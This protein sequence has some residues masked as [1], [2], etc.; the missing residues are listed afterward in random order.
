MIIVPNLRLSLGEGEGLLLQKAAKKLDMSP[1]DIIKWRIARM[2]LDARDKRD[3]HFKCTVE[4]QIGDE[5]TVARRTGL[6]R[7]QAA[8]RT[9]P[10]HGTEPLRG[11]VVVAGAGPAGLFAGLVLARHGYRPLIIERGKPIQERLKD[12]E[13]FWSAGMLDPESNA[14]Y[15]EG[16]AGA[17]SD[18]KLTTRIKDIRKEDILGELIACGAGESIAYEAKPHLGSD[19]LA[20]ILPRLR[21]RIEA[22]GG[23]FMFQTRLDGLSCE[24]GE[25]KRIGICSKGGTTLETNA[26]VLAPGGSARD[27]YAML[28]QSGITL[29]AKAFAI[30]LRI[31]HL[32]GLVNEAQFGAMAAHPRLGAAEYQ[33][34]TRHGTRGVY[35]FCMCPGGVVMGATAQPGCLTVNGMSYSGRGRE[36]SNSAIVVQTG[37]ED[38]GS[39]AMDGVIFQQQWEESAFRLGGGDFSAPAQRAGD[40]LLG[41]AG[42]GFGSVRPTYR[43]AVKAA[44]LRGCLPGFAAEAIPRAIKD[45][46]RM[47]KGFDS[48]DAVLTGVETRT[49]SPVR[50]L[51]GEDGQSVSLKGLY[52]CGEGAGYAGGI[53]SAAVDGMNAAEHVINRFALP[54]P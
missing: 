4:L 11:R 10:E 48:P 31:E 49:S 25:L 21:E 52:P 36:N 34:S 3:I 8:A 13:S 7:T 2:S 33:L 35:T 44:D 45:F 14:L 50:I 16:G 22:F 20:R 43:P 9:L 32:Q 27:T 6:E 17:F 47:L 41:T 40:F 19:V 29:E 38:F 18:G 24:N 46:A 26:L 30:G 51:R 39:D 12:A 42:K 53:M 5:E 28:R 37:P 1:D 54:K 15:G 23:E